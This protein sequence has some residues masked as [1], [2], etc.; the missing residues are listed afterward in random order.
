MLTSEHAIIEYKAG[1]A[2]PDRLN[3]AT[4][5]DYLDCARQMLDVYSRGIG[6]TRRHLH[7]QIE[8]IFQNKANCPLPRIRAFC[9]LLDDVSTYHT[10]P[11]GDSARLRL[12][13]FAWAAQYHPLVTMADRLFEHEERHSKEQLA[14]RLS[15]G[16]SEIEEV[17]Y[18]DVMAFQ[19][20]VSFEGYP[21]ASALLSRY[22]VAQLQASLYRAESVTVHAGGDFKTI[23]R[24]AKL[25]GLLHTIERRGEQTYIMEFTGPLS[26]SRETRRYGIRFAR[27]LP[28]LLAC[29]D[30]RMTAALKTPWETTAKLLLSDRDGFTSHLPA[31]AEFD[32]RLEE[33]FATHF[34]D[35]REG[36]R[37]IR[38][39]EILHQQQK[40]FIPD[41]VFHHEDGTRVLL[42]IVGFWTPEYLNYKR[43]VLQQFRPS[44]LLLAVPER[45]LRPD[46]SV[47]ENIIIYKTALKV[48]AVLEALE[49]FRCKS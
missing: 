6:T 2:F 35:S 16:W 5:R 44:N 3:Q 22:N 33:N 28:T 45:S 23:L 29:R 12:E 10:D 24:Y 38:E 32:S 15:K 11:Y 9:K 39:G 40:V 17:L 43:Q 19:K 26:V 36:W 20:L 25:A 31:P 42:E 37:L 48:K 1:R 49:N 27:F 21:D 14:E 13:I 41:F 47:S 46:A 8:L 34:G 18:A 4:H 7:R 30:W